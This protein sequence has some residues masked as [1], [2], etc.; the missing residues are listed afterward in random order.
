MS[1]VYLISGEKFSC[2]CLLQCNEDDREE[3]VD[4]VK[5]TLT[6]LAPL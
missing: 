2:S 4:M 3:A 5:A 6:S 1:A